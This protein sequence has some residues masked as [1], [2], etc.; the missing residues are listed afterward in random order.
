MIGNEAGG[1]RERG[2]RRSGTREK[3]IGN[4]AGGD[5]RE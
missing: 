2:R 5:D 4:E 1:D 3:K